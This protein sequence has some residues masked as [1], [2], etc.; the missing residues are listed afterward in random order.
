MIRIGLALVWLLRLL[1]FPILRPLGRAI[2]RLMY[3][4]AGRRRAIA[5]TNLRLCFPEWDAAQRQR[6]VREHF[7][8]AGAG[9]LERGVLWWSSPSR[10]RRMVQL[11]GREHLEAVR[12]RPVILLAPHFVGLDMGG[13]RLTL[14]YRCASVYGPQRNPVM[15]RLMLHGRTRF[16]NARLISRKEGVRPI[17]N[18]LRERWPLYYLPDQDLGPRNAVF[19]P[20]FGIPAATIT[21][22]PRLA[23][24]AGAVI[25]PCV[26]RQTPDGYVA[27][28]YPAWNNYPSGDVVADTARMNAFIEM[29]VREMPE[30]YYWLHRRFKTRPPGEPSLYDTE[31]ARSDQADRLD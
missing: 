14:D 4:F 13:T 20:F 11:E 12:D 2:G 6:V 19:V 7:A 16:G 25:V 26:T 5:D 24:M 8:A 27:R 29:V 28:L 22:L 31:T 17:I 18:I 3:V 1:P 10:I 15:N 30:Q 9:L 21:A 23:K